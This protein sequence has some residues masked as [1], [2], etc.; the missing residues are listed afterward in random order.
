MFAK[1]ATFGAALALL[2][3]ASFAA[4]APKKAAQG[5][6][7][8]CVTKTRCCDKVEFCCDQPEKAQC[9][10]KGI[11]CCDMDECCGTGAKSTKT[12]K[13]TTVRKTAAAKAAPSCCQKG[14]KASRS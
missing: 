9:C 12:R 8:C 10:K 3:T 11:S 2:A 14:H 6:A 5:G 7:S 1:I 4:P 13:V